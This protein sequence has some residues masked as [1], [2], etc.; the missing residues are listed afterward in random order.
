MTDS[1]KVLLAVAESE[2][3]V[4]LARQTGAKNYSVIS[5]GSAQNAVENLEADPTIDVVILESETPGQNGLETLLA[6]KTRW[7]LVEVILLSAQ[8][9]IAS[10]V[11]AIKSGAYDYLARPVKM[12]DLV[13][14]IDDAARRKR[15]R[16][17]AILEVYMTPYLTLKQ[18]ECKIRRILGT[19]AG[20]CG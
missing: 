4:I 15:R 6:I 8:S 17:K 3:S 18:R 12:E 19:E 11:D 2:I 1:T 9:T 16:E 13:L 10:A 20:L 14:K 7:P 5:A